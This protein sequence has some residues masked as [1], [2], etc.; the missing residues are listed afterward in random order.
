V[1]SYSLEIVGNIS[2]AQAE[3]AKIPGFTEQ[4]AAKSALAWAKSEQR[5]VDAS[6]RAARKIESVMRDATD[7]SGRS[8]DSLKVIG[9]KTFGGMVGDVA[10]VG[11]ALSALG[12]AGIAAGAAI[13]GVGAGLAVVGGAAAA[14]VGTV[15]AII[16]LERAA[17]D[18]ADALGKIES[19]DL[20]APEQV[21]AVQGANAALDAL[22]V[23]AQK[24]ALD[25]AAELA[26]TVE[27]VAVAL[28]D[29]GLDVADVLATFYASKSAVEVL[30]NGLV[31]FYISLQNGTAAIAAFLLP[32][33]AL[34]TAM[35]KTDG[36]VHRAV[37]AMGDFNR[38]MARSITGLDGLDDSQA[39]ANETTSRGQR[40]VDELRAAYDR[41]TESQARHATKTRE[42]TVDYEKQGEAL[43]S[44]LGLTT[45]ASADTLTDAE[46]AAAAIEAAYQRRVDAA[47][48]AFED[49]A[50]GARELDALQAALAAAAERRDRD[51]AAEADKLLNERLDAEL[52][53]MAKLQAEKERQAELDRQRLERQLIESQ[54]FYVQLYSTA[55]G[56]VMDFFEA[57]QQAD[58]ETTRANIAELESRLA[59]EEGLSA[60]KRRELRGRL[61]TERAALNL[62]A[63][64]AKQLAVFQIILQGAVALAQAVASAPPPVNLAAIA[65]QAALLAVNTAAAIATP[66]PKFHSG[67]GRMA[68]DE[69]Q[70]VIRKGEMVLS[71]RAAMELNR[72]NMEPVRGS[73][74]TQQIYWNGRLMSEVVGMALE[75]PG[76]ARRFVESRMPSRRGYRG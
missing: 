3:F 31:E 76:P 56:H 6:T 13:L 17:L 25:L 57:Q 46:R 61:E 38:Q 20:V 23:V 34:E 32:L 48:K 7:S 9:E 70:A 53:G 14:V 59:N 75:Q 52:A 26:P 60:A 11:G 2:K 43:R 54:Q 55:T 71:E 24:L 64:Q 66:A 27:A 73:A 36:P 45:E 16:D 69:Q 30:I 22:G 28:V 12:P 37:A 29:F 65:A 67:S 68:P 44:L 63:K 50:M 72:G 10:D 4:M 35:G 5:K 21:N 18:Y 41:T 47:Y 49:T 15:N 74:S 62:Q 39:D 33:A 8:L 19:L 1:A 51:Q 58:T 40:L 42:V